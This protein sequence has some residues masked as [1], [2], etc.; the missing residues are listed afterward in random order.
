M[1]SQRIK[2]RKFGTG[3]GILIPRNIL[4]SMQWEVGQFVHLI[5]DSESLII[6]KPAPDLRDI[7]KG[8][9]KK[10]M[11]KEVSTGRSLGKEKLD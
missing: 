6:A 5:L 2:I 4:K 9:P 3:P 1:I 11:F 7:V 8:V 10:K